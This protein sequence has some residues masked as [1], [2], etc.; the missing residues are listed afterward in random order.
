MKTPKLLLPLFLASMFAASFA[1][2]AET[3][4]KQAACCAKAAND[5][6]ACAHACCT[7]AAKDGKNCAKCGGTGEIA[8]KK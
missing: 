4:S 8:K 7:E 1:F 5:G 2:A 3:E 6:A